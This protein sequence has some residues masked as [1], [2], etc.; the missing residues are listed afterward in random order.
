MQKGF[1]VG[2]IFG[3]NIHIDWS[4]LVILLLVSWNLSTVFGQ[5]HADWGAAL[6]WS[7]AILAAILF[8]LSVLAHEFAHS[9]VARSQGVPVHS[10]TL[11]LFG[12]VSNIQR[13]PPSPLAEFLITVVG[14]ALSILLGFGF[15]LLSGVSVGVNQIDINNPTGALGQLGPTGT[16]LTWLGSINILIGLFNLIP[17]FPMDGGRILRSII[18]VFTDDLRQATR[19]ASA[20][21]QGVAWIMI[22][23]GVA[24]AFGARIPFF[25]SGL[26]N[27]LWLAF[28]GWFLNS[29]SQKSYQELVLRDI[30]LGVNVRRVMRSEPPVVSP[31]ISVDSLI[32]DHVMRSDEHAFPVVDADRLLGLVTLDDIRSLERE[33]WE[34]L[35]VRE[36]MTRRDE[37]VVVNPQAEVSD[38]LRK[39][40]TIDVRQMPVIAEG[41]LIGVL[42]R[43]DILRW[44]RLHSELGSA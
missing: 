11:F 10:I 9:L 13:E 42:R 1:R 44:L 15:L 18:W 22:F 2:R 38:A 24:M 3:I 14:P 12:G 26:I 39:L 40:R 8:F 41:E 19:W 6:R 37:L 30:L 7:V 23:S 17:G 21:G 36:I 25:G 27:G 43:R 32:H 28:I 5:I 33:Q 34:S 16:V 4:W 29:A 35:T 20:V 31:D